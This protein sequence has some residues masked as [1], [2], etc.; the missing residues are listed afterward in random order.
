MNKKKSID[1]VG[2]VLFALAFFCTVINRLRYTNLRISPLILRFIFTDALVYLPI[3]VAM[4]LRRRDIVLLGCVLVATVVG[5][6]FNARGM[7]LLSLIPKLLIL[8]VT[9]CFVEQNY[10]KVDFSKI[11]TYCAQI[12]F[13]PGLLY[14]AIY[15]LRNIRMLPMIMHPVNLFAFLANILLAIGYL[16]YCNWLTMSRPAET[17]SDD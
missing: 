14:L 10:V 8:L 7:E 11:R 1:F 4:F 3:A 16:A 15:M 6:N 5:I 9:V 2:A 13:V 12:W 17:K